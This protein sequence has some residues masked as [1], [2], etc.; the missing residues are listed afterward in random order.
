MLPQKKRSRAQES[1]SAIERLYITMRHLFNRGFYKPGGVSGQSLRSSLLELSPEI[2]G[3]IADPD[4]VELNG[5]TYVVDRLPR[6][7]E[8][9]RYIHFTSEEGFEA[10]FEPIVPARRRHLCFRIDAD[11]M[12][13]QVTHG[14]SEIYDALT[15][16]TFLYNEADKIMRHARLPEGGTSREWR[17]IEQL[18]CQ[19]AALD[20]NTREVYLSYLSI[21]LGRSFEEIRAVYDKFAT[22][23]DPDRIFRLVYHMGRLSLQEAAEGKD[24]EIVFSSLLRER[25]G[26]H[27][28]G[29]RWA[30]QVKNRLVELG[31]EKRPLHI[32][33]ANMHSVMNILYAR[34]ALEQAGKKVPEGLYL[35]LSREKNRAL[36]ELVSHYGESHG[37][38]YVA[39]A[40]GANVDV[41]IFDT[42]VVPLL[43]KHFEALPE[44]QAPVLF[45]LDYAFG[46]QAFEIMDELLKPIDRPQGG[47]EYLDVRSVSIMGKAGI[48]EGG[49]GDIMVPTAYIFEGTADN[50]PLDNALCAD[51]FQGCGLRVFEG[52]L[53]TVL[54]TS[55]QNKDVLEFFHRSSWRAIGLEMEGAHY[56]KAIQ[57]HSRIRG[58]IS[59]DVQLNYA[60]YAS[61]NPLDTSLT[62]ASGPLGEA[63]V[64]PT[65]LV[66][67]KILGKILPQI[68]FA[69]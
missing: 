65:Y 67:E 32:I 62:L 18:V 27:V 6:G 48:L 22:P 68:S 15:H 2:Y 11:Q 21:L 50:Y 17:K 55:L 3:S 51:D 1:S 64:R 60:Y 39:D 24:R 41:Q 5:L 36:R 12:N 28:H 66:T 20:E 56:Q 53:I 49:K 54:G 34:D 14:R 8:E 45:V 47:K 63:G 52:P 13:I 30:V 9:C 26:H 10:A 44:D 33:S 42:R 57:A 29:E 43:A 46:E 37:M 16:L 61:D 38:T 69:R 23:D 59:R 7:I 35:T 19:P 31:L 25:I 58:N 40:T 4:K